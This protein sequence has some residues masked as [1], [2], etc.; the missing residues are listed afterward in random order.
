LN[1]VFRLAPVPVSLK[2][3][4]ICQLIGIRF[5]RTARA[6][7]DERERIKDCACKDAATT[8]SASISR[9]N[10]GTITFGVTYGTYYLSFCQRPPLIRSGNIGVPTPV[11][12]TTA[13]NPAMQPVMA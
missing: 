5:R 2:I 7:F 11:M 13:N 1:F 6:K 3:L 4:H 12:M 9:T 8:W 10:S